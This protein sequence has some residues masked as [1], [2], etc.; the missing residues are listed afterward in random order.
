M[1][2]KDPFIELSEKLRSK[3]TEKIEA[4][5]VENQ[6]L[7]EQLDRIS[8]E[9]SHYTISAVK[10]YETRALKAE[11]E[12]KDYRALYY[13]GRARNGDLEAWLERVK[14]LPHTW[15]LLDVGDMGLDTETLNH[16]ADALENALRGGDSAQKG[17]SSEKGAKS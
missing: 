13:T 16:C 8:K 1:T 11:A 15:R 4:L 5:E 14:V 3:M 10:E 2:P 12:V 17:E 7:K 6:K 9:N